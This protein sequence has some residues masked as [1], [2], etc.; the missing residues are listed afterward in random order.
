VSRRASFTRTTTD[1]SV[2]LC[3]DDTKELV[4]RSS[5]TA[6][7]KPAGQA[8]LRTSKSKSIVLVWR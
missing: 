8:T 4:L 5:D 6:A 1:R 3:I 7:R 2:D